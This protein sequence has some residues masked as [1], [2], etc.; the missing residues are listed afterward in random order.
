MRNAYFVL[1]VDGKLRISNNR[2]KKNDLLIK[3]LRDR[4]YCFIQ[5]LM[6]RRRRTHLQP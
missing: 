5:I 2:H 4:L 1:C 6:N 3:K